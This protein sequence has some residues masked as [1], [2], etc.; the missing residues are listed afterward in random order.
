MFLFSHPLTGLLM[1]CTGLA[2]LSL[3][4]LTL[5]GTMRLAREQAEPHPEPVAGEA[6]DWRRCRGR[7]WRRHDGT[8]NGSRGLSR[9]P[10]DRS[11]AGARRAAPGA[12]PPGRR[13]PGGWPRRG[14]MFTSRTSATAPRSGRPCTGWTRSCTARPGPAPG[15]RPPSTWQTNVRALETLVRSA[16]AAGV[17]RVVHVSSITVHGNDVRRPGRRDRAA[18]RGAQSVQPVQGRGRAAAAAHDPRRGRAGDDR[19]PRLDLRT[20]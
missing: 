20:A 18:A 1:T 15:A 8:G 10:P 19:A 4:G 16:M 17:R 12:D 3:M 11:A 5:R 2:C 6:G 14:P 9:R 7:S 13:Q